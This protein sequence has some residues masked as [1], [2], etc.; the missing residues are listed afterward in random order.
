MFSGLSSKQTRGV[1]EHT[2]LASWSH[3]QLRSERAQ[4][5][6]DK[7]VFPVHFRESVAGSAAIGFAVAQ[8]ADC[9]DGIRLAMAGCRRPCARMLAIRVSGRSLA[10]SLAS[11]S[12]NRL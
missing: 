10:D 5:L 9:A 2:A 4:Y 3:D 8:A 7:K 6:S 11:I 12:R 1:Y